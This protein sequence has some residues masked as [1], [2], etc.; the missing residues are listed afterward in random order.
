VEKNW[1]I[2]LAPFSEKQEIESEVQVNWMGQMVVHVSSM[3]HEMVAGT[4]MDSF[5][6]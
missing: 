4:E 1:K 5:I 3:A 6:K 2:S